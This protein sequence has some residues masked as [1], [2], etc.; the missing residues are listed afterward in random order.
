MSEKRFSPEF[1]GT[2]QLYNALMGLTLTFKEKYGDEAV[3]VTQA[4]A[5][6]MGTQMGNQF[7]EKADVKDSGIHDIE[8]VFHAWLGPALAPDKPKT[9]VE[10]K[11]MTLT[12]EAP[13]MC[14]PLLVAKQ[15]NLPLE[16]V[17][18]TLSFPMFKG[19]AKAVNPGAKHT[20]AQIS[21][22]KCVDIIE[23]P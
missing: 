21:E 3:K 11:K 6:R 16:M 8:Q 5:E 19:I 12:R 18:N 13:T 7:K 14:P 23:I 20:S 4:F 17:C 9:S 2:M 1:Q 15:M 10:N 22:Q